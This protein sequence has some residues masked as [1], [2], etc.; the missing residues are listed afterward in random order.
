[1]PAPPD[2]DLHA[3]LARYA[4]LADYKAR[5]EEELELI[6]TRIRATC[7]VGTTASTPEGV[8]LS[9]QPNR[10][11]DKK[12]AADLLSDDDLSAITEYTIS[13]KLARAKLPPEVYEKCMVASGSAKVVIT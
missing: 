2:A 3:L 6:K 5:A 4:E 11:F 7:P 1:M 13:T 9:V 10:R 12:L 8:H